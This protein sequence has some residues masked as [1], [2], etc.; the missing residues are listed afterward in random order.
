MI[1]EYKT[2]QSKGKATNLDHWTL[3]QIAQGSGFE[4]VRVWWNTRSGDV[5]WE[6]KEGMREPHPHPFP[7][8]SFFEVEKFSCWENMIPY[9]IV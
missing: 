9:K 6:L 5:M 2:K 3:E 7:S 1:K 4:L 8:K